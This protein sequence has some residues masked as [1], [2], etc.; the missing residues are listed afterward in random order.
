MPSKGLKRQKGSHRSPNTRYS[1]RLNFTVTPHDHALLFK[2]ANEQG[3][4]ATQVMLNAVKEANGKRLKAKDRIKEVDLPQTIPV[5]HSY[6]T[7]TRRTIYLE[8][9]SIV[10]QGI[11]FDGIEEE[12]YLILARTNGGRRWTWTQDIPEYEERRLIWSAT[13]TIG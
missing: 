7:P 11:M 1:K 10:A 8:S 2:I 9:G 12:Q 4:S 6:S 13:D 3:I 5:H